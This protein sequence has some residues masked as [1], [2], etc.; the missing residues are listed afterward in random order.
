[1]VH[2]DATTSGNRVS[3]KGLVALSD[4]ADLG[5]GGAPVVD[6]AGRAVGMIVAPEGEPGLKA[7]P[8]TVQKIIYLVLNFYKF[9]FHY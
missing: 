2:T 3:L 9:Q 8:G 7:I 4:V 1:M 6:G 5:L